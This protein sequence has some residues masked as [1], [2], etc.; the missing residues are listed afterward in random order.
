MP[1]RWHYTISH[2]VVRQSSTRWRRN[3]TTV[4]KIYSLA[5]FTVPKIADRWQNHSF[6]PIFEFRTT[7]SLIVCHLVDKSRTD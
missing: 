3:A 5:V 1:T 6:S 4:G 2:F 7:E